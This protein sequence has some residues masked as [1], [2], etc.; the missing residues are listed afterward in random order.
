MHIKFCLERLK[1]IPRH[2]WEDNNNKM[3][4]YLGK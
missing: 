3:D 4:L 1:G 2:R